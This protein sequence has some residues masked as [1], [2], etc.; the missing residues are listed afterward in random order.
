MAKIIFK[1]QIIQKNSTEVK[2]LV[3]VHFLTLSELSGQDYPTAGRRSNTSHY[4][5]LSSS[6]VRTAQ[7]SILGLC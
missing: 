5:L 3:Q 2:I 4:G 1:D 7:D 6:P